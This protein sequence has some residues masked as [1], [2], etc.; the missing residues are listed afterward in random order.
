MFDRF[1]HPS[2]FRCF[3]SKPAFT[4]TARI[5]LLFVSVSFFA[6]AEEKSKQ[7]FALQEVHNGDDGQ[8][9]PTGKPL[10]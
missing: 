7:R 1:P 6:F 5:N 3:A 2:I 10:L 8:V 9:R 4:C